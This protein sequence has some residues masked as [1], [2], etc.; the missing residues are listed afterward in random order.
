MPVIPRI[1]RAVTGDRD[2][3]QYL[4][5]SIRQFPVAETF[6]G[7]V[8]D[9]GFRNTRFVRLSGGVVAIHAGWKL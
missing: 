4:V 6:E 2:S 1:G 5:E 9:A 7:M 3:Y 8:R